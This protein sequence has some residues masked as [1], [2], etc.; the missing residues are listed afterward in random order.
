MIGPLL[1]I[2]VSGLSLDWQGPPE[3][4]SAAKVAKEVRSLV[5]PSL[6]A[7]EL[8]AIAV[9][10]DDPWRAELRIFSRVG[11][12]SRT[13]R[14]ESCEALAEAAAVIIA[15]AAAEVSRTPVTAP[16]RAPVRAGTTLRPVRVGWP[17][18]AGASAET[19]LVFGA[20]PRATLQTQLGLSVLRFPWR[21]ELGAWFRLPR[22]VQGL[23]DAEVVG[24]GGWVRACRIFWNR[25]PWA[26]DGCAAAELGTFTVTE[27]DTGETLWFA[28]GPA[29]ALRRGL[30]PVEFR[31]GVEAQ[32]HR[33]R[34]QIFARD[35]GEPGTELLYQPAV[36]SL[37][38]LL[39]IE[40]RFR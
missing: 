29:V 36:A 22:A 37:R 16:R 26:I 18:I 17:W 38:A 40:R 19:G 34:P 13:L 9:L 28:G 33:L 35:P 7:L 14:G 32:F 20:S 1:G 12:S 21:V 27:A 3:C 25:G 31:I 2:A 6:E 4:P 15:L 5:G 10:E 11:A 24:G 23:E 39:G 8:E 30:G